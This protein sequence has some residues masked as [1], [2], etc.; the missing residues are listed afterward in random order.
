M[1][2]MGAVQEMPQ[3]TAGRARSR[4]ARPGR[5]D[6]GKRPESQGHDP[7]TVLGYVRVSTAAQEQHGYSLSEQQER[8]R[9][10]CEAK[11]WTLL[12]TF[13]DTISGAAADEEDLT[14]PRPGFEELLAAINGRSIQYV[15]VAHTS[16]LWRSDLA[17]ILVTRAL[18]KAGLDV[19]SI[20]QPTFSL[21]RSEPS[22]VFVSGVMELLDAYERL[23]IASRTRRGRLQK[24]RQ[25]G[26]SGGGAPYGYQAARGSKILTVNEGEAR[27]VRRIFALHRRGLSP[28]AISDR[29][30]T[31][32]ARTREDAE[33]RARQ[34]YRIIAR[35]AFYQAKEYEY[36]GIVAPAAHLPILTPRDKIVGTGARA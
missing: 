8:I 28:Y 26:Y 12:S 31:D 27:I 23:T 34:V 18:K 4:S 15:V 1:T 14:L 17:R 7:V 13:S 21:Y 11:G 5:S 32:G 33:W 30:N 24:A 36:S 35:R 29:L 6:R 10:Y 20:E 25:G 2:S 9:D 3:G 16:R 19:H 22:D